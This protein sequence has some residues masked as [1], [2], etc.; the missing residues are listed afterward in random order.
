MLLCLSISSFFKKV[1][2]RLYIRTFE[3]FLNLN[4]IFSTMCI[5][6]VYILE[7]IDILVEI[8]VTRCNKNFLAIVA[9]IDYIRFVDVKITTSLSEKPYEVDDLGIGGK[10]LI[11]ITLVVLDLICFRHLTRAWSSVCFTHL[12]LKCFSVK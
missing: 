1:C 8:I 2:F 7:K 5:R 9:D 3:N 11:S 4:I 6:L 10:S 12:T